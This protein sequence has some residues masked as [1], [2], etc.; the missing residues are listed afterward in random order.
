MRNI[1]VKIGL[2]AGGIFAAGML[3]VTLGK[4]GK[5][6]IEDLVNSDSD[7]RI[8]LMGIIPFQLGELKLGDLRRLTL[9]RDAPKH[10]TGVRVEVRLG[11][12]ATID[13]FK[14]CTFLTVNDPEHLNE[15][16]RFTCV[17][18]T[19]D[20]ASFGTVEIKH[21][22]GGEPTTLVRTLVLPAEQIRQLQE[23]MGPRVTPDSARMA[24]LE[25]MGDSLQAMGDSIRAATQVQVRIEQAHTRATRAGRG[26]HVQATEA[27]AAP[28]PPTTP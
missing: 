9:L 3:L 25:L 11:D 15:R 22:Q 18:D 24:Q 23:G 27:P 19:V 21:V 13:P 6:K 26:I 28:T 4:F 16:T 1:W 7:I 2:G 14:D 20:L 12:S 5:S 17:R 8:P 10:L